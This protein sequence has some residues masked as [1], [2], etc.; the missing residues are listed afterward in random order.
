MTAPIRLQWRNV[1][2]SS[3]SAEVGPVTVVCGPNYSGKTAVL[4]AL[5]LA[6][7]GYAP[8]LPRTN[9][10]VMQLASGDSMAVQL[11]AG[12]ECAKRE[13]RLSGGTVKLNESSTWS[14][15]GPNSPGST[16]LAK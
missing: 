15:A 5:R 8:S 16:P 12:A 7:A 10:G 1:K 13:W 2:G 9:Q 3:G 14:V 4:T 6:L 11:D